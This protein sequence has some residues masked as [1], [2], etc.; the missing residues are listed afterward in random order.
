LPLH[1]DSAL[2]AVI[3]AV[4]DSVLYSLRYPAPEHLEVTSLGVV[5]GV[6]VIAAGAGAIEDLEALLVA[7]GCLADEVLEGL[8]GDE[9]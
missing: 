4:L 3:D 9:S 7:V 1:I 2:D 6:G 8:R 5:G